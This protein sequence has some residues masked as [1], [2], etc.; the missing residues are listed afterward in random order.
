MNFILIEGKMSPKVIRARGS[1][2][3]QKAKYVFLLSFCPLLAKAKTWASL[4][5][6]C[7]TCSLVCFCSDE[8]RRFPFV[9]PIVDN[10]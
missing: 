6:R 8:G 10:G 7:G 3:S 2:N 4:N 1:V 9:F 5:P